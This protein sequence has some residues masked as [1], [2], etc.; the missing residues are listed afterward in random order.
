MTEPTIVAPAYARLPVTDLALAG[1]FVTE[2]LGLPP[3]PAIEG[4][5]CFRASQRQHDLSFVTDAAATASGFECRDEAAFDRAAEALAGAGF[6][7][8][9]ADVGECAHRL[10]DAALLTRDRSGNAID[11]VL[12]PH[13]NG[14]RCHL[15]R[16]TGIRF[17]HGIGLRSTDVEGDLAFWA[18]LGAV[19]SDRVGDITYLRIDDHHH[20]I[21]LHPADRPGVLNTVF[22]VESL[23]QVM[24]AYYHAAEHQIRVLHGPGRE[25]VSGLVFVHLAGPDGTIFSLVSGNDDIGARQH[26]PRRFP[27]TTESLCTWGSVCTE[28]PEWRT[29]AAL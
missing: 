4:G 28:V 21:A 11:L 23:D 18:A 7:V 26:R 15:L 6:P 14:R 19:V 16:D 27:F 22:A 17:L 2:F 25:A 3:G 1:R 29:E 9:R 8:R 24:Q 13:Y 5:A 12:R 10:V 20:R